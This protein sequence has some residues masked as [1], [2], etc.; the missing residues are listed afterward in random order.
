M[1]LLNIYDAFSKSLCTNIKIYV[2]FLAAFKI[3]HK[4]NACKQ[5]QTKNNTVSFTLGLFNS[6]V[7]VSVYRGVRVR[8]LKHN[9]IFE[10]STLGGAGVMA[11]VRA[12]R[13]RRDARPSMYYYVRCMHLPYNEYK[14][15]SAHTMS[16]KF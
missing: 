7:H 2:I 10:C 9:Y 5:K 1:R 6:F 8:L 16:L 12:T 4:I 15:I 13:K 14:W 11:R 3:T